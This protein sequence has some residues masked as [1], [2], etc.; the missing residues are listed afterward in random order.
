[1]TS[2]EMVRWSDHSAECA[3]VRDPILDTRASPI[4]DALKSLTWNSMS[5]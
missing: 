5:A 2:D 3:L 1:M 4:Y